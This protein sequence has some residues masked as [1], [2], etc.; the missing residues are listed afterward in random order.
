M[1]FLE[2]RLD[3]FDAQDGLTMDVHVWEPETPRALFLAVHG[4]LA[5]G[6]DFV[7]PA[8]YFKQKGLATAA[9]DLR[10]HKQDKVC[11][12]SFEQLVNDTRCFL[13][14]A[15]N[16]YPDIPIFYLGH[17]IGSLIGTHIGLRTKELPSQVKGFIFSSPYYENAIKVNPFVVPMMKLLSNILPNLSV[18]NLIDPDKLTHDKEITRRHKMDEEEGIRASKVSMRFGS[19]IMKAQDWVPS[20]ISNWSH[21]LWVVLAGEDEIADTQASQRV[22]QKINPILITCTTR[23][24]NFH[25]N[26]NEID[27]DEIF[28]RICDWVISKLP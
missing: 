2:T 23:D 14:W 24:S 1:K 19:E 26:F 28:T 9:Y 22:L 5:H 25:E 15:Q 17:S 27:R 8:L 7:T 12:D 10:G 13:D 4:G 18:P 6:G 16:Q 21:P 11:I 20:N 3:T